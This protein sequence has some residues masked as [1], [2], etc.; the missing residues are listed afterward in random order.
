MQRASY[1][2]LVGLLTKKTNLR[3]Q[4]EGIEGTFNQLLVKAR[5]EEAKLWDRPTV[6]AKASPK[7]IPRKPYPNP[8]RHTN[9]HI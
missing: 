8:T 4:L 5:F 3:S 6:A 1:Q 9:Q 7:D 2:Q